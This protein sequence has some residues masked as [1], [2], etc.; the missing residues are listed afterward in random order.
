MNENDLTNVP[1]RWK[2]YY[3]CTLRN[4]VSWASLLRQAIKEIGVLELAVQDLTEAAKLLA[5]V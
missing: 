4:D 1:E 5:G 2:P 3:L